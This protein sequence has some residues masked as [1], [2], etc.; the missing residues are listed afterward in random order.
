MPIKFECS[1]CGKLGD[2]SETFGDDVFSRG[3]HLGTAY[4]YNTTN[5][6][7]LKIQF[8]S[9]EEVE[10][11]EIGNNSHYCGECVL[12]MMCELIVRMA[13]DGLFSDVKERGLPSAG[14]V[15]LVMHMPT[16]EDD[17]G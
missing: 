13:P 1:T 5:G 8:Q 17:N 3:G 14:H 15:N 6:V 4:I 7:Q 2:P 10:A 9:K 12:R 11:G 16:E